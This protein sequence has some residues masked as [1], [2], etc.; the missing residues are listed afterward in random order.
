[1]KCL[2]FARDALQHE[3]VMYC[4]F[5]P[6]LW[7]IYPL[8]EAHNDRYTTPVWAPRIGQIR[9][10]EGAAESTAPIEVMSSGEASQ[11]KV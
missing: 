1:M 4:W 8:C 2:C 11:W 5:G 3:P 9:Q 7:A 6:I 10:S